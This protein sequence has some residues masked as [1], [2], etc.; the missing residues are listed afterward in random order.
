[1]AMNPS[2]GLVGIAVQ[3]DR[4]T[5]ATEPAYLHGLTGGSPF[6]MSRSV[7]NTAVACGSRSPSD[8]YVESIEYSGSV[9]SLCYPDAFGM[10]LY[11]ALG[12]DTVTPVTGKD[13]YY[14]HVFRMAS[15]LPF[16]TCWSQFDTSVQR[17]EG[18]ICGTLEIGATG[19][20]RLTMSASVLGLDGYVDVGTI[21]GSTQASCYDGKFMTTDCTFKL[22]TASDVPADALVSEATFTIENNATGLTSLG[23]ANPRDIAVGNFS[24]GVS[25][26]TIPDDIS[27]YK[28]MVTGSASETHVSSKLV[29]GSVSAHF[30]HTDDANM[31]LDIE[32]GHIPFTADFP[33]VDPE[34]NE[35]TIQ[36]T[37][38]AAIVNASGDS[39]IVVTLV[40]KVPSY[41]LSQ[42]I[43]SIQVVNSDGSAATT[44][45]AADGHVDLAVKVTDGTGASRVVTTGFT[46][47]TSNQKFLSVSGSRVT[48]VAAGSATITATYGGKKATL[49]MTA[50]AK[51]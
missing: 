35:A 21:P 46:L 9:Q 10:W 17:L 24:A 44:E 22:D 12:E 23:R 19:N 4:D 48:W 28:K 29:L 7:A 25:V 11:A 26:T 41:D 37:S 43:T 13:G 1:M 49:D 33:E 45:V 27:M 40:N 34:G 16:L 39:P 32:M 20:E 2:I 5:P 47:A 6:G 31:T 50:A 15:A 8:A 30:L 14:K 38:D 36:F 42:S 3:K 51:A 18:C